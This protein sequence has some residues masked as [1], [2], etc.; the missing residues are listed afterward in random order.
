MENYWNDLCERAELNK[1]GKDKIL[2]KKLVK[3]LNFLSSD[4][5]HPGLKT[6]EIKV[7]TQRYGI[8]VW[9]SY[10]ESKTPSAGRLFWVY[11]P[12][13]MQITIIGIEPHPEDRKRDGYKTIKLSDLRKS[14]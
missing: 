4:P 1:L 8:K 5:V 13:K 7:L 6:H 10:L 2:F 12:E 11:G 9:Q 3:T 14:K